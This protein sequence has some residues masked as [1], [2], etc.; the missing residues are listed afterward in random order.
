MLL[1]PADPS[2]VTAEE[3][4]EVRSVLNCDRSHEVDVTDGEMKHDLIQ[5]E[6]ELM[7]LFV[8]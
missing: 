8:L 1:V 7:K 5:E 6:K 3:Q 4:P 2:G